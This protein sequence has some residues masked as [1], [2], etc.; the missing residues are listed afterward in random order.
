[1]KYNKWFSGLMMLLIVCLADACS[2][3][4]ITTHETIK[5]FYDIKNIEYYYLDHDS[6]K[7]DLCFQFVP[8]KK[9]IIINTRLLSEE[10]DGVKCIGKKPNSHQFLHILRL[11]L[12]S[13]SQKYNF[14]RLE[15][16]TMTSLADPKLAAEYAKNYQRIAKNP[17]HPTQE[18]IEKAVAETSLRQDLNEIF[19]SYKI[20]VTNI[21]RLPDYKSIIVNKSKYINS[22]DKDATVTYPSE[23]FDDAFIIHLKR[24]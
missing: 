8:S 23:L 15:S 10:T 24:W 11:S 13:A 2:D 19:S 18:E 9:G 20:R 22:C 12:K 4:K 7:N 1:M 14:R 5:K 17:L 3:K 21:E 16:I 6:I